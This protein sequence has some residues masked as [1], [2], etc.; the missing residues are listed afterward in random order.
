MCWNATVSLNTFLFSA[1]ITALAYYNNIITLSFALYYCSFF[2]IQLVEFFLWKYKSLNRVMSQIGLLLILLQPFLAL[3]TIPER[4]IRTGFTLLYLVNLVIYFLVNWP[5]D[6][7]TTVAKNGHLK[8]NWVNI[9][10]IFIFIWFAFVLVS[11]IYGGSQIGLVFVVLT[12]AVSFWMYYSS[13]TFG[14]TW[15]FIA[16]ALF[17]YLA[18]KIF[19]KSMC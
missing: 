6:F 19:R 2:G 4:N 10:P 5:I 7:S 15:C 1:F 8:W 3:Q 16:N 9:H 13:G 11:I 17:I 12:F 14:S 18:Y